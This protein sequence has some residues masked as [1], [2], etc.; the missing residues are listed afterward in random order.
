MLN[1]LHATLNTKLREQVVA[2]GSGRAMRTSAVPTFRSTPAPVIASSDGPVKAG[3]RGGASTVTYTEYTNASSQRVVVSTQVFQRTIR[4]ESTESSTVLD[5]ASSLAIGGSYGSKQFSTVDVSQASVGATFSLSKIVNSYNSVDTGQSS[6]VVG[7]AVGT[8]SVT[9]INV[10]G[11]TSGHKY[12]LTQTVGTLVQLQ[13]TTT[14]QT[15]TIDVSVLAAQSGS[16]TLNFNQLG[17]SFT[18]TGAGQ[19]GLA[20]A[21]ALNNKETQVATTTD[22]SLKAH[23]RDHG[24]VADAARQ[25]DR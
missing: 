18:L 3:A 23:G 13:D 25:R 22:Y 6:L 15:Q 12:K 7:S 2:E 24:S 20:V 11:A 14:L 4:N 8:N 16:K 21:A 17:V 5:E 9:A 10:S 19:T 1:E